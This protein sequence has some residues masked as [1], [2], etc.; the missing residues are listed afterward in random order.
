MCALWVN[1]WRT[2]F[3]VS[4]DS[5]LTWWNQ[6]QLMWKAI[7]RVFRILLEIDGIRPDNHD[8]DKLYIYLPFFMFLILEV[9]RLL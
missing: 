1:I 3:Q 4:L 6:F 7:P 2:D 8:D 9:F 5:P